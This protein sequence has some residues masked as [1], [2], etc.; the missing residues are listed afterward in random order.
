MRTT[1]ILPEA[2]VDAARI[3]SGRKSKTE[4][5]IYAL[6]EVVRRSK[7]DA[8]KAMLGTVAVQVDLAKTRGRGQ[9]T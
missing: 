3:A 9:T 7:V 8:L 6:E 2:L 1:L 4:T 5:I